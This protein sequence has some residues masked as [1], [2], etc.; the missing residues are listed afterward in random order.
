MNLER[1]AD[2]CRSRLAT[3]RAR[4]LQW[5]VFCTTTDPTIDGS[6]FNFLQTSSQSSTVPKEAK[7]MRLS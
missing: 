4:L 6:L 5:Q 3:K 2:W 7:G 1:G